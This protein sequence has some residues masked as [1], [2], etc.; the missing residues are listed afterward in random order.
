MPA[1]GQSSGGVIGGRGVN[2]RHEPGESEIENFHFAGAREHDVFGL[3]VEV[4]NAEFVRGGERLGA[5][6]RKRQK[7]VQGNRRRR[8]SRS[9]SPSTYSITRNV[10]VASSITS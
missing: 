1:C 3:E 2:L 5:L 7:F 9:V 6:E 4:E 10:S 8:R